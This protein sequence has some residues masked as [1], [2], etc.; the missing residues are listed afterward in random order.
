MLLM[1]EQI[2][3]AAMKSLIPWSGNSHTPSLRDDVHDP[4]TA[5]R[6]DVERV[7]DDFFGGFAGRGF[8]PLTGFGA[9]TPDI[10]VGETDSEVVIAAEIPGLDEKDFDVTL[11]GDV[12]TIRGEKRSQREQK[13]GDGYYVERR[14]GS[15]SRSVRL[16]FVATEEKID[17]S[18]DK[19]ILTIRVQKPKELQQST[20]RIDVRSV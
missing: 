12:L 14:F 18:Y 17:A 13:N 11:S 15:F 1:R 9:I 3:D 6:R 7:F 19:G 8:G 2:G 5:F 10:D 20:R 16:P 4:F